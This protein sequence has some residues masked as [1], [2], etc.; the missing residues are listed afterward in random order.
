MRVYQNIYECVSETERELW[1]MGKIV[2]LKTM[3]N[4]IVENDPLLGKTKEIIGYTFQ[5]LKLP[6]NKDVYNAFQFLKYSPEEIEECI[7]WSNLEIQE[8]LNEHSLNPGIAWEKRKKLWENLMNSEGRFDYTY[9][10]R[11]NHGHQLKR[12]IEYMKKDINTRRAV[13]NIHNNVLGDLEGVE[14]NKRI[15]CSVTYSFLHRDGKL[16]LFYHMRS[17]DFYTHFINDMILAQDFMITV[18]EKLNVEG[19][20]LTV[21]I[22]SLHAYYVD[23][24][25]RNIF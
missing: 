4:K 3:Q 24:K 22:N 9:S 20:I 13:I 14:Q 6:T 23:L 10:E 7:N 21:Y 11:I 25:K 19:G 16:N 8:R 1:E 12:I 15:P 18:A 2:E 17:S 5:I